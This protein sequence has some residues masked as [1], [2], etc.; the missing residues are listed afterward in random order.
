V[1]LESP[2]ESVSIRPEAFAAQMMAD[3]AR[4]WRFDGTMW[5]P[6]TE[7]KRQWEWACNVLRAPHQHTDADLRRARKG[8]ARGAFPSDDRNRV[9]TAVLF[10]PELVPETLDR[11]VLP[12]TIEC[13]R[14]G[15]VN[16]VF[17]DLTVRRAVE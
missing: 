2:P 17:A 16:R 12:T 5:R 10:R 11:F 8:L 6:T 4:G 1:E 3:G 14:C 7:T 13:I 9:E 15:V